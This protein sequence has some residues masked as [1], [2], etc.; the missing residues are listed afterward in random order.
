MANS[1]SNVAAVVKASKIEKLINELEVDLPEEVVIPAPKPVA[2]VVQA[3]PA[4][5]KHTHADPYR[6]NPDPARNPDGT[7][8][9]QYPLIFNGRI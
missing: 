8:R 7:W 6:D 2:P 3:K 1:S 4:V 9:V 5:P